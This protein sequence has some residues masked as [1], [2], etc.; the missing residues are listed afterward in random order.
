MVDE[1]VVGEYEED[2]GFDVE[3]VY[4]ACQLANA[5]NSSSS[6]S[7]HSSSHSSCPLLP[8][9]LQH[10]LATIEALEN[11]YSRGMDRASKGLLTSSAF[12]L[13]QHIFDLLSS[14]SSHPDQPP[15][16]H[17]FFAHDSTLVPLLSRMDLFSSNTI[18]AVNA[19]SLSP[20]ASRLTIHQLT[21]QD[22]PQTIISYNGALLDQTSIPKPDE[23]EYL[24]HCSKILT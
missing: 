5:L 7:S 20:F 17:L 8:P 14:P 13:H 15:S 10:H 23:E 21:C 9:P 16:I 24:T 11:H 1:R 3:G 4:F 18:P 2:L 22:Q 6:H 12:H 19:S